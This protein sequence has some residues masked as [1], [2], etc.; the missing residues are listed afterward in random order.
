MSVIADSC[1]IASLL[2]KE[3]TT[4]LENATLQAKIDFLSNHHKLLKRLFRIFGRLLKSS[5]ISFY[6]LHVFGNQVFLDFGAEWRAAGCSMCLG[7]NGDLIGPGERALSTA[8]RNFAGRQGPGSRTHITG[9]VV[10]ALSACIG[11]IAD[12][13]RH[14]TIGPH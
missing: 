12:P 3:I 4:S 2:S 14:S 7:A 5:A 13:R 11:H 8:N 6:V 10:A 1:Q 9:P